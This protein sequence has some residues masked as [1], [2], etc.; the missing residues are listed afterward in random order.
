MHA[1][2]TPTAPVKTTSQRTYRRRTPTQHALFLH[3]TA[4]VDAVDNPNHSND[5][6]TEFDIFYSKMINLLNHFYP[7]RTVT[8]SSRDP[9]FITPAI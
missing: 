8:V 6:Q 2:P 9:D 5:I 3:V 1:D 4:T 7:I